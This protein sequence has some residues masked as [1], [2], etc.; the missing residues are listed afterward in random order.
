MKIDELIE[1]LEAWAE[2]ADYDPH[3]PYTMGDGLRKAAE[4]I[5]LLWEIVK[6]TN[7]SAFVRQIDKLEGNDD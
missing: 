4:T 1:Q 5:K 6:D 2:L 3:V 7:N